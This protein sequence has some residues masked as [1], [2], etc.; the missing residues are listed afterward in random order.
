MPD[1]EA[2]SYKVRDF[3]LWKGTEDMGT[4]SLEGVGEPVDYRYTSIPIVGTTLVGVVQ[5]YLS[6]SGATRYRFVTKEAKAV[7]DDKQLDISIAWAI[8]LAV[9]TS[10]S[11]D[12]D[13]IKAHADMLLQIKKELKEEL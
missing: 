12:K 6:T 8:G 7:E 4:L 13:D 9:Q 11:Y 3:R 1:T 5:P 10:P 2:T